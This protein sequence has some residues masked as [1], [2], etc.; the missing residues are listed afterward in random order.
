MFNRQKESAKITEQE[1]AFKARYI[2]SIETFVASGKGCTNMP[3][4]KLWDNS[5]EERY[6]KRVQL[7]IKTDGIHMKHLDS[8]KDPDLVF[9]IENIS[10]CN[11]ESVVNDK[12]FSWIY[13]ADDAACTYCHA[14]L[15][16]NT[17][18]ARAIALVLSRAFQI[19]YKEWK[20][21]KTKVKREVEKSE[22]KASIAKMSLV[23]R[24]SKT[25]TETLDSFSE[26]ASSSGSTSGQYVVNGVENDIT[27]TI[28][29]DLQERS[30]SREIGIQAQEN[31]SKKKSV[32]G[33]GVA[34][35]SAMHKE[36]DSSA[37]EIGI[38]ADL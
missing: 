3:V 13:K 14:V 37:K 11:V 5:A 17:E 38:Q 4:Q 6:L 10:F 27:A 30:S 29:N 19:A 9:K 20:A 18:K 7:R 15:C 34:N 24:N 23:K 33:G 25:N 26:S 31:S 28:P 22:R 36:S 35:A 21:N 1:P 8:K 16:S 32:S 2:G 12:I